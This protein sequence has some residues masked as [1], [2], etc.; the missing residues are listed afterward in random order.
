MEVY[1]LDVLNHIQAPYVVVSFPAQS[2]GG[3]DKGM[4]DHYARV[5]DGVVANL[6]WRAQK[7]AFAK[8]TYYVLSREG[9]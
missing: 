4:T 5:M 3:Q 2:I 8:E 7:L 9:D 6:Q 1:Q